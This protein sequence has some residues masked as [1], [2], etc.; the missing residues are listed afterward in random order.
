[1]PL[2]NRNVQTVLAEEWQMQPRAQCLPPPALMPICSADAGADRRS[3]YAGPVTGASHKAIG[4]V[5]SESNPAF[6]LNHLTMRYSS[7]PAVA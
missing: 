4:A 7:I 2:G 3:G 1:M 6:A 5:L